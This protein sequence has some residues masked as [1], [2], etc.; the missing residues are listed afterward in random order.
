MKCTDPD[1]GQLLHAYELG[2]LPDNDTE[3]FEIHLIRCACCY[4]SIVQF[5]TQASLLR[6]DADVLS[7]AKRALHQIVPSVTMWQRA[8]SLLWPEAPMLL[9]PAVSFLLVVLLAYPAYLGFMGNNTGAIREV[10]SI[11]LYP[12]RSSA[13]AELSASSGTDALVSF[14]FRGADPAKSYEVVV[15]AQ[16]GTIL[17]S[18]D[19]F[20]GFDEYNTGRLL[21]PAHLLRPGTYKLTITDPDADTS[22]DTREYSFTV[23]K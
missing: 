5:D 19:F 21:I 3:R 9:R 23:T 22:A 18:D 11:G 1:A 14:V 20:S 8:R 2:A 6:L 15:T 4:E 16:N 10:Q 13:A 7:Q 17:M 12:V